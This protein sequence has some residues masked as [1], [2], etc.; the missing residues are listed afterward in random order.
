MKLRPAK[1]SLFLALCALILAACASGG[2]RHDADGGESAARAAQASTSRI[3]TV[4]E[5]GRLICAS[6]KDVAGFGSLDENG[7]NVGFDIDLCRAVAA[8]VLG[9]AEAI[10][11]EYI[12]AAQHGPTIQSGKV[13]LLVRTLTRT[14]TRDAQWGRFSYTMFH[15]GQGFLA[16]KELGVESACDLG[17]ATVCVIG[18]TTTERNLADFFRQNDMEYT[19]SVLED[20]HVALDAYKSGRCEAFTNDRSQL[21]AL[22]TTLPDPGAH[23]ILPE[24]ISEEPLTPIVPHGDELWGAVVNTVMA[25][26]I[27]AEAYGVASDNLAEMLNSND[28]RIKR[29]LGVEGGFG[30]EDLKLSVTFMQDVIASVGNYGEIYDRNIGKDGLGLPRGRNALWL[31]GGQLYAAPLR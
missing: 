10:E 2:E 20:T 14:T 16:P 12:T 15:D 13:D 1:A 31:D 22:R 11:I 29:M 7:R 30:Q 18:G 3:E 28:T 23:V 19:P 8:A 25:G 6:R 26:L 17:G 4:R 5:R 27:Y 24:T 21:A 9:D